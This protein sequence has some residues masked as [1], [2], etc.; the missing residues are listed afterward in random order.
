M[1]INDLLIL[2]SEMLLE[3]YRD[4]KRV[5]N[6]ALENEYIP[7]QRKR[8]MASVPAKLEAL[9]RNSQQTAVLLSSQKIK[10]TTRAIKINNPADITSWLSAFNHYV[11]TEGGIGSAL[12]TFHFVVLEIEGMILKELE[13]RTPKY[14]TIART[15]DYIAFD[16]E[17]FAGAKKLRNQVNAT[18]CIGS[19]VAYFNQYGRDMDNKTII[20]FFLKKKEG[21]V[22]HVGGRTELITSHDNQ[23]EWRV[24]G[25]EAE[26]T[27]G[28]S[29]IRDELENYV[30]E[31]NV[32][33]LIKDVGMNF[34]A[35]IVVPEVEVL[36]KY[37]GLPEH[38]LNSFIYGMTDSQWMRRISP[39]GIRDEMLRE[40]KQRYV[41]IFNR[42]NL[43]TI[44]NW[45][46]LQAN[47]M[48]MT[49]TTPPANMSAAEKESYLET[50]AAILKTFASNIEQI[51][52]VIDPDS[53][54]SEVMSLSYAAGQLIEARGGEN[55]QRQLVNFD[56]RRRIAIE[57]LRRY[58]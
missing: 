27:R 30:S 8:M 40:I 16:V 1:R 22:F 53:S 4:F 39:H 23:R 47:R 57:K 44:L 26:S 50:I 7:E 24:R 41:P 36:A 25:R 5:W 31:E 12:D 32:A 55:I 19:D 28:Y 20:V 49:G 6:D 35:P 45:L 51:Q 34:V 38:V 11:R 37:D 14:K 52:F 10:V 21:M 48:M 58:E 42:Q 17:N 29:L 46:G 15:P 56:R 9:L 3:S 2:E 13:D 43:K 18:W 54:G 33:K